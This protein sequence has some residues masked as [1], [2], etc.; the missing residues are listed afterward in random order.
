M[1][2]PHTSAIGLGLGSEL[3]SEIFLAVVG[4]SWL[5]L[6]WAGSARALMLIHFYRCRPQMPR[7]SLGQGARHQSLPETLNSMAKA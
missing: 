4:G 6:G 5:R 3:A 2:P 7:M 1:E